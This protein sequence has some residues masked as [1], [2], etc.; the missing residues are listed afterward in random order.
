MHRFIITNKSSLPDNWAFA[1]VATHMYDLMRG[2]AQDRRRWLEAPFRDSGRFQIYFR[3]NKV[4][5]SFTV[6]DV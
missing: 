6:M 5:P 4:T 1:F 3:S 2:V